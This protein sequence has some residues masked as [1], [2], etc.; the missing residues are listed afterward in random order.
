M[1]AGRRPKP[2][3]R[4]SGRSG[5]EGGDPRRARGYGVGPGAPRRCIADV[6]GRQAGAVGE[7]S[8]RH[9]RDGSREV[10]VG[11]RTWAMPV[12]LRQVDIAVDTG[13]AHRRW[14]P[15]SDR[16]HRREEV[17]RGCCADSPL[18][19]RRGASCVWLTTSCSGRTRAPERVRTE[20]PCRPVMTKAGGPVALTGSL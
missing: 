13:C 3:A 17:G 9:G 1:A 18:W 12:K 16:S 11:T 10:Q 5:A 8:A 20:R 4:R 19:R 15:P 7:N 6:G 2:T 14:C